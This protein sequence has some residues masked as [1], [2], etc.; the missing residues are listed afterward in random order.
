MKFT[1]IDLNRHLRETRRAIGINSSKVSLSRGTFT[2]PTNGTSY[3]DHWIAGTRKRP[4]DRCTGATRRYT[5]DSR[6]TRATIGAKAIIT[7]IHYRP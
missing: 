7:G 6:H 1:K 3:V 5:V 2:F 4:L